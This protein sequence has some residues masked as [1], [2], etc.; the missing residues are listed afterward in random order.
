LRLRDET[1]AEALSDGGGLVGAAG[2][3]LGMSLKSRHT[4]HRAKA[5]VSP[6]ATRLS[7]RKVNRSKAKPKAAKK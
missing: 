4:R 2:Y 7:V 1:K 3:P 6:R 5:P